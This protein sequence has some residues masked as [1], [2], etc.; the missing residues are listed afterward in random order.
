[1]SLIC[2]VSLHSRIKSYI[3]NL[4]L[5]CPACLH[6]AVLCGDCSSIT[7][8]V[9]GA[10]PGT[11]CSTATTGDVTQPV[12]QGNWVR[13]ELLQEQWDHPGTALQVACNQTWPGACRE[14]RGTAC[15][16]QTAQHSHT[17]ALLACEIAKFAWSAC[18]LL[19]GLCL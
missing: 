11:K 5:H 4:C 14:V 17:S 13:E 15:F 18:Q 9:Q 19:A 16:A 8:C 12:Q 10:E 7:G 2:S 6:F 3:S 1:M